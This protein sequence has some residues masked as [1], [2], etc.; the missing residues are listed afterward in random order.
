MKKY[1]EELI[2]KKYKS[3]KG[4]A[5]LL[6]ILNQVKEANGNEKMLTFL[7]AQIIE[8]LGLNMSVCLS[9][10]GGNRKKKIKL[11][12]SFKNTGVTVDLVLILLNNTNDGYSLCFGERSGSDKKIISEKKVKKTEENSA[13]KRYKKKD[14]R[15]SM[16]DYRRKLSS[17]S[18]TKKLTNFSLFETY[19]NRDR[20]NSGRS[21]SNNSSRNMVID[22]EKSAFLK[23]S[24]SPM[25][26]AKG[27]LSSLKQISESISQIKKKIKRINRVKVQIDPERK[28]SSRLFDTRNNSR[29]Q[30]DLEKNPSG[31]LYVD[32]SNYYFIKNISRY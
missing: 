9:N 12:D 15:T 27:S 3:A 18:V 6:A 19:D 16:G 17:D 5:D 1:V 2:T 11:Y 31:A 21:T 26:R 30:L 22:Q 24:Q 23:N 14:K 4:E 28:D 7:M 8:S 29:V 20:D 13:F 10:Q 25:R 32:D